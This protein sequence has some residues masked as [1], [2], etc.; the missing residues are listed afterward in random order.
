MFFHLRGHISQKRK[1]QSLNF[2]I[3]CVSLNLATFG[4]FRI[5]NFHVLGTLAIKLA[6]E[7]TLGDLEL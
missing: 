5:K 6:L 4:Y 3:C 7:V 2:V 1:K